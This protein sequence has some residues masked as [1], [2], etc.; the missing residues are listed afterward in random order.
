MKEVRSY[1][2]FC[3]PFC[4][5]KVTLDENEQIVEVK[6]DRD[7]L[8]T[9]GYICIKGV[10][11]PAAYY[12]PDRIQHPMKRMPDGSFQRIA[13]EQALDEIAAVIGQTIAA[14]GPE[15]IGGFRGAGC[16][17]NASASIMVPTL[18]DAI[19][20]HK[21]F[22][23][24]TIDQSAKIISIG[25]IGMWQG[26]RQPLHDSDVRMMFGVNPLVSL[27]TSYFDMTNPTK[28]MK[29]ARARGMKLIV[30]DPRR[31]ETAAYADVFLQP[32]PG[33]DPT[34]AAGLLRIILEEGWEDR[35]FCD[36]WV[37]DLDLLR[38]AVA[39]FTPEYVA[40]RAGVPA[41]DLWRAAS[42][43]ARETTRGGASTGT[44]PSMA[45]HSNLTEHLVECLNVVCGRYMRAGEQVVNP[46]VLRARFAQTAQV[47]AAPRWWEHG[48]KSRIGGYGLLA[49]EMVSGALSDEILQPGEGQIRVLFAHGSNVANVVPDQRKVVRA[50][51][52]LDLLVSI[53]PYMNETARLS[54]YVFPPKLGYERA[55]LTMFYYE[56]PLYS[57]PYARYAAPIAE[58]PPGSEIVDDWEVF[59]G[60]AKRLGLALT[61]DGVTLDMSETPTTDGL[62]AIIARHAPVPWETFKAME[63]GG[64]FDQDPQFVEEADPDCAGRFTVMPDDVRTELATVAAEPFEPG[65]YISN[66][67]SFTHRLASRR[68][69]DVQNSSHRNVPV[70]RKRMPYNYAYM[71]P[72]DLVS[73]GLEPG[74]K[75]DISSDTGTIPGVVQADPTVRAGVVSMTHGWGTLPDETIYERDGS[76]TGLLIS[77]DRD[78]DP[79]NGMPR[80]SAVP[81]NVTR[82]VAVAV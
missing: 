44:G 59:W 75:V 51:R 54:H 56:Q 6:P 64:I 10:E 5:T 14:H 74:D 73:L 29:D 61:Y 20:S 8:M 36:R 39:P 35:E 19:G 57:A 7:D 30:I 46:G 41:E 9:K 72:G 37:Q 69:R 50:L 23:T 22:T 31:T 49:G 70:I 42:L 2:R 79:I 11:A 12:A 40:R 66:G 55:D 34:I 48:F 45:P 58:T 13:L 32:H 43:F 68:I 52:S 65:H 18:L 78:V 82:H 33:E 16:L 38:D 47:L 28:R 21:N 15:S 76:N 4:G 24:A 3:M 77:T 71:N 1:C 26:G 27:A 53:E 60:I 67:R 80:M 17:L 81:V 25:R 63:L 62:L